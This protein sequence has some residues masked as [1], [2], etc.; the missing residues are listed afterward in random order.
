MRTFD[1][2][3]SGDD[4]LIGAEGQISHVGEDAAGSYVHFL[5]TDSGS[6][7]GSLHDPDGSVT[8]FKIDSNGDQV[9]ENFPPGYFSQFQQNA[10]RLED[11]TSHPSNLSVTNKTARHLSLVGP[12]GPPVT[13]YWDL[14]VVW[15]SAAECLVTSGLS[16]NCAETTTTEENMRLHIMEEISGMNAALIA[17]GVDAQVRLVRGEQLNYVETSTPDT[18]PYYDA[19]DALHHPSDGVL[20]DVHTLRLRHGADIVLM[21]MAPENWTLG[22]LGKVGPGKDRMFSVID[23]RY[24]GNIVLAHEIGHNLGCLHD[25]GEEDVCHHEHTGG[26]YGYRDPGGAF[27]TIMAYECSATQCDPQ[28][29]KPAGAAHA[30]AYC[31]II[32]RF[33]N[34]DPSYTWDNKPIG[35]GKRVNGPLKCCKKWLGV[36]VSHCNDSWYHGADNAGQMN[37]VKDEVAGYYPTK[38][39]FGVLPYSSI[40]CHSPELYC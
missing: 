20:D 21:V 28:T 19:L 40:W 30:S 10:R 14:L 12:P 25:R 9:V 36:C 27:R 7:V 1:V 24:G 4:K 39:V 8:R 34:R 29:Y 16:R 26:N 13:A 23:A 38:A 31:P 18:Q 15:T 37:A 17:S 22:G 33:S 6:M 3:Q 11:N 2:G 32:P 35:Y 5:E